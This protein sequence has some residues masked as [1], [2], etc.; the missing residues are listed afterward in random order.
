V[1]AA[2]ISIVRQLGFILPL[3]YALL[4][5]FGIDAV[6]FAFPI[7]EAAALTMTLVFYRRV[8]RRQIDLLPDGNLTV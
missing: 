6:W 1:F 4:Y 5:A 3:A 8:M 2:V 7:A